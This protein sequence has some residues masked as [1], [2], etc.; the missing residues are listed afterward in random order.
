LR[1]SVNF[2][3]YPVYNCSEFLDHGVGNFMIFVR[4]FAGM[5]CFCLMPIGGGKSLCY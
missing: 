4:L 5:D 1:Y 2:S 3:L